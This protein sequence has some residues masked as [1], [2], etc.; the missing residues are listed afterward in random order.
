M[1]RMGNSCCKRR[2]KVRSLSLNEINKKEKELN[3]FFLNESENQSIPIETLKYNQTDTN[4]NEDYDEEDLIRKSNSSSKAERQ[5]S[6][7]LIIPPL[8]ISSEC[9]KR[10]KTIGSGGYG[11]VMM[12]EFCDKIYA[13][14]EIEKEKWYIDRKKERLRNERDILVQLDNPFLVKLYWSFQS[15]S[16]LY[17][18]MDFVNGGDLYHHLQIE[19]RFSEEKAKFYVAEITVALNYLH[20][21]KIVYR[22]L[23]PENIMIDSTGHIKLVDF[24]LSRQFSESEDKTYSMC[25]T[26]EY[27]A[28]EILTGVGH[29]YQ[30]DWWALGVVLYE[31]ICG[32]K[33]FDNPNQNDLFRHIVHGE[34]ILCFDES[35]ASLKEV[36]YSLLMKNPKFRWNGQNI[37]ESEWMKNID[38]E[39]LKKKELIPP[40][41][42][43]LG[44]KMDTSYF[45]D[46]FLQIDVETKEK[47]N[48]FDY[49][50]CFDDFDYTRQM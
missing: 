48:I 2:E 41:I 15:E 5:F 27:V 43:Q 9:F 32:E 38:K 6:R 22:D 49:E 47:F 17:M 21:M 20:D 12:V 45:D 14:K 11:K 26:A 1:M 28:P 4:E 3:N 39:K 42:P 10:L 25:G 19:K 34:V 8:Q 23:K 30:I 35:M 18:V 16:Y 46:C 33:P 40:F 37:L 31:M 24:G 50:D 29:D 44:N 13:M 36:I 7:D